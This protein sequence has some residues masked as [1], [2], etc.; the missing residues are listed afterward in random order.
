MDKKKY[1]IITD[2]DGTLLDHNT[3]KF[4][5]AMRAL[6]LIKE[7][8]IPIILSSSKTKVEMI[9]YQ[10]TMGIDE[11]PFVVENGSAI[12]TK[13][14][15]FNLSDPFNFNTL[16]VRAFELASD[17][18]LA[19]SA[20]AAIMIVLAGLIPVILLSKSISTSRAGHVKTTRN[21]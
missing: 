14:N 21:Q 5:E 10:K 18:R 20:S 4:D 15:Y 16:A 1:I 9:G 19:D 6:Q 12:Y 8:Q 13:N 17:E 3:Y 2:L 7:Q 11:F